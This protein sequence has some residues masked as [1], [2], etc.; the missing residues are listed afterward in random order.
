MK[1]E[2]ISN[3]RKEN[4]DFGDTCCD[5]CGN[6][7]GAYVALN[8]TVFHRPYE[9]HRTVVCKGCLLDWVELINETILQIAVKR[10][11]QKGD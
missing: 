4:G 6:Y 7:T 5:L 1:M 8:T 11:R 10:G 9:I 3:P 2:M